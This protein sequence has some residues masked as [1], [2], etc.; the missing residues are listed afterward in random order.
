ME[1]GEFKMAFS[2]IINEIGI[3]LIIN[4]ND[5]FGTS[6]GNK[7]TKNEFIQLLLAY[8]FSDYLKRSDQTC[9]M[10]SNCERDRP[11]I[12]EEDVCMNAPF[13]KASRDD[14]CPFGAFIKAHQLDTINWY[15]NG[16]LIPSQGSDWP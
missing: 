4:R 5:E 7:E 15:V 14:L 11:E 12:M 3:P 8:E 10:Y 1:T 16:T 9:P 2:S 6:L 13:R